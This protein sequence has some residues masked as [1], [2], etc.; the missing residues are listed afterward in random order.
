MELCHALGVC[1]VV[2]SESIPLK[3]KFYLDLW[4]ASVRSWAANLG[5]H[6]LNK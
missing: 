3:L 1:W 2:R 5:Y 4:V 6:T